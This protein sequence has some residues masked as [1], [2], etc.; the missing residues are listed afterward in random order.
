MIAG[1]FVQDGRDRL[2]REPFA[3]RF[4]QAGVLLDL[5]SDDRALVGEVS[6]LL[7]P[8][9]PASPALSTIGARFTISGSTGL[10][11]L[12]MPR[13]EHLEPTDLL[14]AAASPDF[15]FEVVSRSAD[16]IVLAVRGE[17][18]AALEVSGAE[19]RFALR[20][21]WRKAVALLLLQRLMRCR[22]DAIFFHAAS[23]AVR[24]AGL[25]LIGPKGAGKST[26][27]L[28]LAAR[29]HALL[30]DENACYLP[31]T[32]LLV[33][34][35]RPV[36]VKPGPRSGRVEEAL[37]ARG[38][39]P[40]R[41]G[42]MRV[43]VLELFPGPEPAPAPLRALV[44]LEGFAAHPAL[45]RLDPG[46]AELARLQPVASSMLNAARTQR[47]FEMARLLARCASW[48]LTAGSPDATAQRLD[49][50]LAS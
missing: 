12:D 41:D 44:F 14:L 36:G 40:E 35:R 49:E 8:A 5:A 24:G 10:L 9:V 15:P 6:S 29:G 34:F 3:A 32:S 17:R 45:R 50:A 37:R 20:E 1:E 18:A 26:L 39:S 25:L 46:R 2:G 7:G 23:A 43:P 21:G 47:V 28:A 22:E 30:G 31:A 19:C 38:R 13:P 33:P 4:L 48:A 42:M 27:V 11:R 16:G